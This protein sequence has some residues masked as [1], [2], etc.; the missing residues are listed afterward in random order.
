MPR[1]SSVNWKLFAVDIINLRSG[2]VHRTLGPYS[3]KEAQ[4]VIFAFNKQCFDEN[5]YR[6]Y[7]ASRRATPVERGEP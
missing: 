1:D 3:E 7:A 4:K 5:D 2:H 6:Y